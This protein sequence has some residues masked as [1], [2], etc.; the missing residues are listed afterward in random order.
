M[1]P[2]EVHWSPNSGAAKFFYGASKFFYGASK[3]SYGAAKFSYGATNLRHSNT[4]LDSGFMDSFYV[5]Q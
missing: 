1:F 2:L 4:A 3:F 5:L